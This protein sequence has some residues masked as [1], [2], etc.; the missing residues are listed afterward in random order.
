MLRPRRAAATPTGLV[1]FA[2]FWAAPAAAQSPPAAPE[3]LAVGDWLL[4]P[5]LEV[6]A[7]SEYRRDAPDLGGVDF[8]GRTTERI[9][10]SW[11]VMERSRIGL[12]AER[13]ALKAQI[14][15][16]DARAAGAPT[17][18]A[19]FVSSRG[20]DRFE[21]Y[22][23]YGEVRSSAARPSYVR[24]GRQAVVWG[25]G[26]LI[27]NADF[28]PVGRSLD[29]ARGHVA[30][31]N[32]DFEAL[33]VLLEVPGPLGS[34]FGDR[35]GPQSSGVQLYGVSARWSLDP[36]F[37]VEAFGIARIARSSG[38]ELD[39]SRFA[40]S[41]LA[42][43]RW[44]GA[45]RAAGEGK[46]WTYG[47]EGAY[48]FGTASSIGIGG[49]KIAAW[50]AA[51][52]VQKTLDQ[53]ALTPTVRI[54]AS[55]AS[56]DDGH[57]AYKQFDPLLPDPQR[58]H[59]QMDLFGW[60]NEADVAG[61]VQIVPWNDVTIAGEYRYARLAKS[62]GEWIGSYMQALGSTTIPP[63]VTATP[64]PRATVPAYDE[65]GHE[66]DAVVSWRPWY[67]L[68]LRAGWSTLFLGDGAKAIM[69]AHARGSR[70]GA[71][72]VITPADMSQY[73]YLQATLTMP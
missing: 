73:G 25:E 44:T 54:G 42:G 2:L 38:D 56:G 33:A 37:H 62:T 11:V 20:I 61:R 29:A 43:E 22:E 3:K 63:A 46:G 8:F 53:L 69:S 64:G 70:D 32:F 12:G 1:A 26:R 7:R 50:G 45:L 60:S 49:S 24:L 10:D 36:L 41:R 57:G 13:G 71:T 40:A 21:P 35:A 68:E 66:I 6:R 39:G 27:G 72:N 5:S 30:L 4:S 65:L 34:A 15:L 31:G 18:N 17:P 23:A 9:R 51:A 55:Y 14:T 48:Q 19:T 47:A 16:Q 52:H 67:P 28:S 58:F 59:G